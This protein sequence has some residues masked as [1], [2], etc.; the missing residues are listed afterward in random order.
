M[1][2]T[3]INIAMSPGGCAY[4]RVFKKISNH[5]TE[6]A[7]SKIQTLEELQEWQAQQQILFVKGQTPDGKAG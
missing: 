2:F 7:S 5:H 4:V 1:D 6:Q 3:I